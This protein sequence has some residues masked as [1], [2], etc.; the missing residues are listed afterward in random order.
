MW[1]NIVQPGRPHMTIWGVHIVRWI[2]KATSKP[3]EC[4]ILISIPLQHWL[5]ERASI[6]RYTYMVFF[7]LLKPT[8]YVMQPT[9]LK[10]NN[11][12]LFPHCIN[13]FCIYLRTNSDLCHLQ[14]KLIGFCNR[15]EKCLERYGL[16]L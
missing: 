3:S 13:A 15:D 12:T 8:G 16:G 1:K 7:S 4:V 6:L 14:P 5:H 2:L 11:C 10:L 9:G